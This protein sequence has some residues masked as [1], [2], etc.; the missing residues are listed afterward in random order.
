LDSEEKIRRFFGDTEIKV[1]LWVMWWLPFLHN[2]SYK[3]IQSLISTIL[4][5]S[6]HG[7]T[8]LFACDLIVNETTYTFKWLFNQF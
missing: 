7:N 4:G 3:Q 6:P 5:V 1:I 8:Y 2:F